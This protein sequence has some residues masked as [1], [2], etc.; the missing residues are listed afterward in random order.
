MPRLQKIIFGEIPEHNAVETWR[1]KADF[2]HWCEE[3]GFALNW[4]VLPGERTEKKKTTTE[5]RSS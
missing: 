3:T 2:F 1:T 5:G 4:S